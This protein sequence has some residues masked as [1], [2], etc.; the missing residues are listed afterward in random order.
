MCLILEIG[1]EHHF[2]YIW[3]EFPED[4]MALFLRLATGNQFTALLAGLWMH[5]APCLALGKEQNGEGPGE[6]PS[7]P[8]L[9]PS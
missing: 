3:Y 8:K 1:E 6:R 5:W 4:L 2:S 7:C 9:L